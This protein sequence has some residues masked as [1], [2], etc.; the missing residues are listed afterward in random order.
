MSLGHRQSVIQTVVWLLL[1]CWRPHNNWNGHIENHLHWGIYIEK[2]P[3]HR[4]PWRNALESRTFRFS[5]S[6]FLLR[7]VL[8]LE[9]MV[10]HTQIFAHRQFS[11]LHLQLQCRF[12]WHY[13]ISNCHYLRYYFT[14]TL[15]F[16][17]AIFMCATF[18]VM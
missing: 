10:R 17:R 18:N 6:T 5:S 8:P 3:S 15:L 4:H 11:L 14:S 1:A 12:A 2:T 16:R 13:T 9:S 7:L